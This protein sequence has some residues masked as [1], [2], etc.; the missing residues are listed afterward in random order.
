MKTIIWKCIKK[1]LSTAQ[2]ERI[3]KMAYSVVWE[4]H[5][6]INRESY[7]DYSATTAAVVD[8]LIHAGLSEWNILSVGG[9]IRHIVPLLPMFNKFVHSTMIP[10]E[11]KDDIKDLL[12]Q[13]DVIE[14]NGDFFEIDDNN[15]DLENINVVI[16]H[17]TIHC[18]NDTRYHNSSDGIIS[19]PYLFADKV[20]RLCPCVKN[21]FVSVNVAKEEQLLNNATVLSEKKFIESF[22]KEGFSV[23]KA[24]Y[25]KFRTRGGVQL[26]RMLDLALSFPMNIAKNIL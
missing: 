26:S 20:C 13:V 12:N 19:R 3:E 7:D 10:I 11:D 23:K 1:V 22:E 18:M 25:D 14:Y 15:K 9:C 16:S 5:G 21:I 17:E 2:W 8:G 6:S 24:V 4:R